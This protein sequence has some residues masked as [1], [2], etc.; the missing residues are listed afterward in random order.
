MDETVHINEEEK[1][2]LIEEY[3]EELSKLKDRYFQNE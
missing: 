2:K 3:N 1:S